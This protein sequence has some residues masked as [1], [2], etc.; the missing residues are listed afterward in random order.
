M[1]VEEIL[2]RLKTLTSSRTNKELAEKLYLSSDKVV[3]NWK[4]RNSI[5]LEV[6]LFIRKQY[7]CNM[8]WLL[9]GEQQETLTAN[10][11]LVLTAFNNLDDRKKIEFMAK[12]MG[13]DTAEKPNSIIQTANGDGNNLVAGDQ[14]NEK[15][16]T[17][18]KSVWHFEE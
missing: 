2:E 6:L 5:P 14:I 18:K 16:P 9:F 4:T 17:R 8:D 13:L 1:N 11:K 3:S 15:A 7:Q 12:I 10:E